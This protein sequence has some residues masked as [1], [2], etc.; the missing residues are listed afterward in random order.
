MH[1]RTEKLIQTKKYCSGIFLLTR[2]IS[3]NVP[4]NYKQQ[5][6]ESLNHI[7]DVKLDDDNKQ[8][9]MNCRS[10]LLN[11][12]DD[13]RDICEMMQNIYRGSQSA[14]DLF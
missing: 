13:T 10:E 7:K 14:P 8:V 12:G 5:L 6:R 9:L 4:G 3:T 1:T 11:M 2:N